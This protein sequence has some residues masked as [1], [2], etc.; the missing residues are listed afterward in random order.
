M[1]CL[2]AFRRDSP[3]LQEHLK[4]IDRSGILKYSTVN[5]KSIQYENNKISPGHYC[6]DSVF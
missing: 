3:F 4:L 6:P 5:Q 1:I 2:L